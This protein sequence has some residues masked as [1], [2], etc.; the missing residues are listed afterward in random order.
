[1][2][3]SIP[4][5]NFA[6]AAETQ[7]IKILVI[8]NNLSD[9]SVTATFLETQGFIVLSTQNDESSIHQAQHA[10]PD[11]ILLDG[12]DLNGFET[13]LRLQQDALLSQIPVIFMATLTDGESKTK[14]LQAGA[15][16]YVTKPIHYPELFARIQLHLTLQNRVKTL[17]REKQQLAEANR[18]L[19]QQIAMQTSHIAQV[20][21]ASNVQEQQTSHIFEYV[22]DGLVVIDPIT[23]QVLMANAAYYNLYD[24]SVEEWLN[25]TPST[26]MPSNAQ[27]T[28]EALLQTIKSGQEFTGKINDHQADD[29]LSC[30]EIKAIPFSYQGKSTALALIRDMSNHQR[31]EIAIRNSE[32]QFRSIFANVGDGLVVIDLDTRKLLTANPAYCEMHG[33]S[34]DELLKLEPLELIPPTYHHKYEAF[35][36]TVKAGQKFTCEA[37]CKKDDGTPF[38]IEIKSVPFIFDN[39]L[40]ALSVIR[41]VTER[42]QM[43]V[44]MLEAENKFRSI[45]EN[46]SDGLVII[47]LETGML[48]T[49]NPAYCAMHGYRYDEILKLNPLELIQPQRH[50]KYKAFLK[51]VRAG[52]QFTCEA[53]CKKPDGTPFCIEIKSVPFQFKGRSTALS[54]IR[55]M[56]SRKQMEQAIQDKNIRLERAM[57]QLQQTQLHL[58]QSEKMSSLGQLVAG[59]AHEINNPVS[60]VQGNLSYVQDYASDLLDIVQLYQRHYPNP[61]AEITAAVEAVDLEFVQEDLGKMLK[62]MEGGTE[63]ISQVVRSLRNFSRMD[64]ADLK[65]VDIHQGI[66]NTLM[67]L[68][69]RLADCADHPDIQVVQDYGDLPPVRCYPG[70]LNQVFMTLL[71]NAIDAFDE[72]NAKRTYEE[73]EANPNCIRIRTAV[74][75]APKL[76]DGKGEILDAG[77]G[78]LLKVEGQ[79]KASANGSQ[80]VEV[81][82]ADNGPGIPEAIQQKIFEPFFTTKPVGKGTGMGLSIS[83]QTIIESH[84]GN[85]SFISTEGGGTEFIIQIP[86]EHQHPEP[87][88]REA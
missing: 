43:E 5:G 15:V 28:V 82:I 30:L 54:V 6:A 80:W 18:S 61:V 69:H 7:S 79:S 65:V 88:A 53:N 34:Y 42:K 16:D 13:C 45:F 46:V 62:S 87:V 85:L 63:R 20:L 17:A 84:G 10:N 78:Q 59:I 8:D 29:P 38:W 11:L 52:Q 57:T 50:D 60:F 37:Q 9:L 66:D 75:D 26:S 22:T 27:E 40:T 58:I 41:D 19:G 55:D 49:A 77:T 48:L 73:I 32:E 25:R 74:I 2:S 56:T 83:Y 31:L 23:R 35:L 47:D 67:I 14:G 21:Q 12:S 86:I 72:M 51:S 24:F 3:W 36:A 64:E 76:L 4:S 70:R 33:Y 39:R 81:A 1:M 68:R 44:A 71:T